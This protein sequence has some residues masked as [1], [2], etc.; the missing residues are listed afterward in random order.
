MVGEGDV[1]DNQGAETRD[2]AYHPT[3]FRQRTAPNTKEV[4]CP[5]C[6]Y[7]E[8]DKPCIRESEEPSVL[9]KTST[10]AD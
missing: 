6:Q 7:A 4:S 5:Q 10:I 2:V 1:I 9:L 3:M 8:V